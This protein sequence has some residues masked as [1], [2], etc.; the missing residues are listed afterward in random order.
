MSAILNSAETLQHAQAAYSLLMVEHEEA[1]KKI[2]SL[3]AKILS[4][5]EEITRLKE[6]LKLLQHWRFGKKTE[7]NIGE[8]I[9][10]RPDTSQTVS[11]YTRRKPSKSCG[12]AIDTSQLI[13][14]QFYH[15]LL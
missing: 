8:P 7:V 11:G 13:R 9:V 14:H 2:Q 5:E 10:N 4:Q 1:L 15:A 12:R 3:Y 6:Q